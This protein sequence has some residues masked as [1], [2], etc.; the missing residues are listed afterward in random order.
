[1]MNTAPKILANFVL[2]L[3]GSKVRELPEK[4]FGMMK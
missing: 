4:L 3:F 2:T 1:M